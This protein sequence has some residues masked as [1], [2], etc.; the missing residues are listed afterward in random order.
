MASPRATSIQNGTSQW[1]NGAQS[2]AGAR[3]SPG[4][5]TALSR[6][7]CAGFQ[8]IQGPQ[9]PQ[10]KEQIREVRRQ[11]NEHKCFDYLGDEKRVPG[12]HLAA[13][14]NYRDV[15]AKLRARNKNLTHVDWKVPRNRLATRLPSRIKVITFNDHGTPDT[16]AKHYDPIQ[17]DKFL[18]EKISDPSQPPCRLFLLEGLSP[19]YVEILGSH[20]SIDPAFFMRHQRTA[21][22]EGRHRAGN[23]PMLASLEDP[24]KSFMIE[25]A[26][27]LYFIDTPRNPSLRNP[28]DNRHINVSRKPKISSDLDQVGVMHRKASFWSEKVSGG[29]NSKDGWNGNRVDYA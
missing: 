20:F 21:L 29:A 12:E 14:G 17:L 16:D 28:N 4:T 1:P 25:Y 8:Q 22:W 5:Q 7:Q 9:Q 6:Q 19:E 23:T 24:E 10:E 15:I 18:S 2:N 3:L 13:A 26:E 11:G 27:L